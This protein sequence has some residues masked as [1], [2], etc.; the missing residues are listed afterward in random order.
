MKERGFYFKTSKSTYFYNDVSGNVELADNS[1]PEQLVF[2]KEKVTPK[3]IDKKNL[4]NFI[5]N[6]GFSQLILIV[7]ESCNLR[8]KYC[9]YSGEYD[10]NRTHNYFKMQTGTAKEAVF[11]Y[12]ASVT[13]IKQNKPFT[14][15]MIGFYGGE[16][17][18]NYELIKDIVSYAKEVYNGKI[19]FNITTN[20]TL[21]NEKKIKFLIE[22]NFFLSISLNG[23]KEENDRM[24]VFANN[25][26]TFEVIMSKLRFIKENYPD[27]FRSKLQIIDVFDI[28]T[29]LYKLKNFYQSN[30]LVKNKISILL[31]VSDVGTDWYDQYTDTDKEKFNN[32]IH[33][34]REEFKEKVITGEKLD[35]LSRLLF[36]LPIYEIIN[37]PVNAPI[38]ELKPEF[39]PYTGT[40]VPGTKVAVDTKGVLHSCEKVNDKMPIGTV[41]GWLDIDVIAESLEKYNQYMGT[42]CIN[43]PIHRL[44]P[45]CFRNFID[46]EGGFDRELSKPCKEFMNEK[47]NAFKTTYTLLEQGIKL[48]GI[49]NM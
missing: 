21:L 31:Q 28:G 26:G 7:T 47:K 32:Q 41:R 15:P 35:P 27:Y 43:C 5:N 30:E 25:K 24:R 6:N 19:Y 11:K 39:L 18:L 20:A 17:L 13:K 40:C 46:N 10:N 9:L 4:C 36:A 1:K 33:T 14:I 44:C 2:G 42:Q 8:C 45:T 49:L 12:L 29:D 37:R 48:D 3:A 23:Y 34:L 16:P 38:K 22:N